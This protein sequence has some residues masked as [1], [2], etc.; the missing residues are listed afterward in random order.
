MVY[1]AFG[2]LSRDRQLAGGATAAQH[3]APP[4]PDYTQRLRNHERDKI[5]N[6]LTQLTTTVRTSST[7]FYRL[8]P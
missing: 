7:P 1:L 8:S 4:E 5:A 2:V 3:I 6:K